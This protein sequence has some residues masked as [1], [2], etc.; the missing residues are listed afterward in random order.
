MLKKLCRDRE[1]SSSSIA[2][3]MTRSL[4]GTGAPKKGRCHAMCMTS[5]KQFYLLKDLYLWKRSKS[6]VKTLDLHP[7][8]RKAQK[9]SHFNCMR[10][11]EQTHSLFVCF[12][13]ICIRFFTPCSSMRSDERI[14]S[15]H[16]SKCS[17]AHQKVLPN[18]SYLNKSERLL[19][20]IEFRR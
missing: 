16:L 8:S 11:N 7:S 12:L 15:P 5:R 18:E 10:S 20:I 17:H 2:A 9:I 4:T 6:C 14:I 13:H 1:V 3:S 19:R